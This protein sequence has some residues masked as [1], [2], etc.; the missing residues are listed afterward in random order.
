MAKF[1]TSTDIAN[2]ACQ[3][4]GVSLIDPAVGLEFEQSQAALE[5]NSAY[6]KIRISE[7]QARC[8]RFAVKQAV[9]RPVDQ[10]TMELVPTL[11]VA[12]TTYFKGS[13]VSDADGL[14]WESTIQSNLGNQPD[15]TSSWQQYFG[16][17]SVSKYD[18]STSYSNGELVYITAGDGTSK[19]YRAMRGNNAVDPSLPNQWSNATTYFK[20]D[21]VQQF[22]AWSSGTTYSQGQGALYT[23]GNVYVSLAAG[24]LNHPP[25]A[26][27]SFWALL[28]TLIL[29]T[30]PVPATSSTSSLQTSPVIEWSS[31]TTY[32]IGAAVMFNSTEYVSVQNNNTANYPNAASSTFWVAITGGTLWMSLIDL[33]INNSPANVP[34]A[35]S[36]LTSYSTGNTVAG[37]DGFNYTSLVNANLNN[38]PTTD[39]GTRW[40]RGALTAWTTSFILGGGNS[41]WLLI[42]DSALF[43][44]GVT[45]K[46]L[47][48]TYPI[49]SGPFTD[50]AYRSVFRLPSGFLRNA[51]R[52]PKAGANSYNGAPTNLPQDDWV[53]EGEFLKSVSTS[54]LTLR[55]VADTAD[56][57][58]MDA[59]FCEA[60][61]AK[62][63]EE[64]VE[65]LTQSG[66]KRKI[67][68][69]VY[70]EFIKLAS[71]NNAIISGATEPELDDYIATRY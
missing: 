16:P 66:E 24:N 13:I 6:D 5:I 14:A 30:V 71:L 28:P 36:S 20:N 53:Y 69:S 11:W 54:K 8:W 4:L 15:V 45:L 9:L 60:L 29:T 55:F 38:N 21:V 33:S 56:V 12:N 26:S 37:T 57:P 19:I 51:P 10:N 52:D 44:N 65:R 1:L 70:Q 25:P 42:G 61:A 27:A 67:L 34:A 41:L 43:P 50:S 40:Q 47:N 35:W 23:D 31:T 49:S 64:L 62:I 32:S 3:Q 58:R 17:L 2:R 18:S 7:L 63:G 48:P 68:V 59:M 46:R 39:N 22:P